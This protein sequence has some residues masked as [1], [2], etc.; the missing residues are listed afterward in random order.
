[1]NAAGCR[2]TCP[3]G[4]EQPSSGAWPATQQGDYVESG[5]VL[6]AMGEV[7]DTFRLASGVFYEAPKLGSVVADLHAND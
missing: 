6:G 5:G 3:I 4:G 1:M 2:Q 7:D